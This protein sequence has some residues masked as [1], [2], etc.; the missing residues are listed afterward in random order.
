MQPE[1]KRAN[2]GEGSW[3]RGW[4]TNPSV[5][6]DTP[7]LCRTKKKKWNPTHCWIIRAYSNWRFWYPQPSPSQL[8]QYVH[9]LPLAAILWNWY[10]CIHLSVGEEVKAGLGVS[11]LPSHSSVSSRA[12]MQTSSTWFLSFALLSWYPFHLIFSLSSRKHSLFWGALG[13]PPFLCLF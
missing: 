3:E 7:V 8:N 13:S 6:Q 5:R 9:K 1:V 12:G 11:N 2:V 10:Y 4:E